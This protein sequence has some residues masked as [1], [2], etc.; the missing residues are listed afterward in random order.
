MTMLPT[1]S[2]ETRLVGACKKICSTSSIAILGDGFHSFAVRAGHRDS[3]KH[4]PGRVS[5]PS[6]TV[7]RWRKVWLAL[8]VFHHAWRQWAERHQTPHGINRDQVLLDGSKKPVKKG[9]NKPSRRRWIAP[10]AGPPC[11]APVQPREE[12]DVHSLPTAQATAPT[13]TTP[14]EHAPRPPAFACRP[15]RGASTDRGTGLKPL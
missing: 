14:A 9:A 6:K 10:S 1:Q 3:L 15:C 8:D 5:V 12:L 11:P 13:A 7:Q 2:R 4:A